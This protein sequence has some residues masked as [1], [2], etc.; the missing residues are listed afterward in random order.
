MSSRQGCAES[1]RASGEEHVLDGGIDR[2]ARAPGGRRP[3]LLEARDD[4][5]RCFVEVIGQVL[6]R[7]VL[8]VVLLAG[9]AGRRV[10]FE[11]ARS[12]DLVEGPLV[13]DLHG[14]LDLPILDDQEPPALCVAA[15]GRADAGLEDLPDQLVGN[16]VR[17]QP[18]HG[19]HVLHGLE[20][21]WHKAFLSSID[22]Q[23]AESYSREACCAWRTKS[24]GSP[25]RISWRRDCRAT[26]TRLRSR[27]S[28][29][30]S[31]T[32]STRR[33]SSTTTPS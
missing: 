12:N 7:G 18:A 32:S 29:C 27:A 24:A 20:K 5:H 9:D 16:G 1:E 19:A 23:L 33:A 4:P 26:C 21:V 31:G 13:P 28:R 15:V 3:S 14:L 6:D 25:R 10:A 22:S 8:P 11:I 17:L 30:S 2:C